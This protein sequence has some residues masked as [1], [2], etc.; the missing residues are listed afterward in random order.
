MTFYLLMVYLHLM[1]FRRIVF[2][3]AVALSAVFLLGGNVFAAPFQPPAPAANQV[4]FCFDSDGGANFTRAGTLRAAVR[5]GR[6]V[7][8]ILLRDESPDANIL[9]ERSCDAPP[10]FTIRHDCRDEGME[11]R[12]GACIRPNRA[13]VMDPILNQTVDENTLL[14]FRV[15]ASDPD[16]DQLVYSVL[17][18]PQ[19]ATFEN[20]TFNW[21]PTYDQAG[22]YA[23]IFRVS[24]GQLMHKRKIRI[25]VGNVNRAPVLDEIGH[26]EVNEGELLSFEVLAMDPDADAL[27]FSAENL[28]EGAAF[29]AVSKIFSWTSSNQQ[30]GEYEIVFRV[31]DGALTDSET[32]TVLVNNVNQPPVFDPIG[33]KE[34]DEG[35]QLSFLISASD[36]DGELLRFGMDNAPVGSLQFHDNLGLDALFQWTPTFEQ[37]GEYRVT[38]IVGDA[39]AAKDHETVT[40]TVHNVNRPPVFK[41]IGN[42]EAAEGQQLSFFVVAID[43]EREDHLRFTM[44]NAPEGAELLDDPSGIKALFQWTPTYQ[45]A[46]QYD[47]TFV[48]DDGEFQYRETIRIT[49]QNV[50]RA[51]VFEGIQDWQIRENEDLNFQVTATDPDGDELLYFALNL[52]QGASFNQNTHRFTWHPTF[53]QAGLYHVTFIVLDDEFQARTSVAISVQNVNRAPVLNPIGNRDVNV[54]EEL[55]IEL[56]G[57]DPDGDDL[58]YNVNP[59]PAGAVLNGNIFSWTPDEAQIGNFPLTFSASDDDLQDEENLTIQVIQHTTEIGG[60]IEE[61]TVLTLENSPYVVTHHILV[62]EGVTLTIEPGVILWFDGNYSIVI[63]GK[64]IAQGTDENRIRFLSNPNNVESLKWMGIKFR[65]ASIGESSIIQFS[66]IQNAGFMIRRDADGRDDDYNSYAIMINDSNVLVEDNIIQCNDFGIYISQEQLNNITPNIRNNH[67]VGC[68]RYSIYVNG[69]S[70]VE[71]NTI[72]NSRS[73]IYF[74]GFGVVNDNA[75]SVLSMGIEVTGRSNE[76]PVLIGDNVIVGGQ[77]VGIRARANAIVNGNVIRDFQ[78]EGIRLGQGGN[79]NLVVSENIISGS[80]NYGVTFYPGVQMRSFERNTIMN[81]RIGIYFYERMPSH[82]VT[83]HSNNIF[84]NDEFNFFAVP[85]GNPVVDATNNWWGSVD[86]DQIASKIHDWNDDFESAQLIIEPFAEEPFEF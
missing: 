42:K 58:S 43:P 30:A 70:S 7:R 6:N 59:L 16:G 65:N 66:D 45:Q 28:P 37:A 61:D 63:E 9:L 84:D 75:L 11:S 79:G 57:S 1:H 23:V 78:G 47:V 62:L 20:Q 18:L 81:N 31:S 15:T 85:G 74:N 71:G 3:V 5:T 73:G 49:V 51:P 8:R 35:Q 17:N 40:I 25:I 76:N 19:G 36:P 52:P 86:L 54:D 27:T 10:S 60:V 32:I 12:N 34:I 26:K 83:F 24:D 21:T 29:D 68:E 38:F 69:S 55:R 33:D 2:Q 72:E 41:P 50:N 80:P 56:S 48:V 22:T 39:A 77:F 53:E 44:D 4:I 13:P 67:I 82:A 64:L 46:G 14:T